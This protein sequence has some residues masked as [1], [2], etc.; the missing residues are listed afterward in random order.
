[1]SFKLF[2]AVPQQIFPCG[3]SSLLRRSNSRRARNFR[4]IQNWNRERK[5]SESNREKVMRSNKAYRKQRAVK[6]AR[7]TLSLNMT[8]WHSISRQ[9]TFL[10]N[11]VW[12]TLRQFSFQ[13]EIRRRVSRHTVKS[14]IVLNV[15]YKFTANYYFSLIRL[16]V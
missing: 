10:T 15:N 14:V 13:S 11:F 5:K 6:C 12:H 4:I 9:L 2:T 3:V 7:A 16:S 8:T 1:M